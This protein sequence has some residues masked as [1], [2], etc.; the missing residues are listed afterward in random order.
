LAIIN[1]AIAEGQPKEYLGY[2]K[3]VEA[4]AAIREQ[5]VANRTILPEGQKIADESGKYA[6]EAAGAAV[7]GVANLAETIGKAGDFYVKQDIDNKVW[8]QIDATRQGY[9]T[10][11]G[12][13]ADAQ[14]V[15]QGKQPLNILYGQ[16]NAPP[17]SVAN[18]G[19]AVSTLESA[20]ANGKITE[21]YYYQRLAE[22]AKSLRAEHPGY[23]RLHRQ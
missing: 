16:D 22:I 8:S 2:S 6:Y 18:V 17:P 19:P 11:V 10:D 21:T 5:G 4:P 13:V 9:I 20:R 14:L 12:A 15:A 1:P 3:E 7:A 23:Q